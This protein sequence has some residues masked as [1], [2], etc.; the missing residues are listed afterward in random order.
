MTNN[1]P[2]Q[3]YE[4][5]AEF[6]L[7]LDDIEFNHSMTIGLFKKETSALRVMRVLRAN[8]TDEKFTFHLHV[9]TNPYL[10]TNMIEDKY[11]IF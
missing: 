6:K 1:Q 11:K 10:I 5:V 2:K 9:I 8:N 3:I 7:F 4:L